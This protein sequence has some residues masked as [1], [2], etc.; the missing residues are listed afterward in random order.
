MTGMEWIALGLG[1]VLFLAFG[2]FGW[3][4]SGP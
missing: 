2:I 1:V 4:L 3:E